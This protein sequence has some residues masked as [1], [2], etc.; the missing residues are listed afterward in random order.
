M[1]ITPQEQRGKTAAR[2]KEEKMFLGHSL[3]LIRPI[4]LAIKHPKMKIG[5]V[6][7]LWANMS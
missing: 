3:K 7:A 6:V 4:R 2:R 1:G 5:M